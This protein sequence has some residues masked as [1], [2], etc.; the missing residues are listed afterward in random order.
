MEYE[1]KCK[2]NNVITYERV[3]GNSLDQCKE[4]LKARYRGAKVEII[5]CKIIR[6]K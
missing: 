5:E 4:L 2:I 6:S 3:S 1:I